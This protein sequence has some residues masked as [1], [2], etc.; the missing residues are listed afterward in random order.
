MSRSIIKKAA[1]IGSSTLVS[2]FFAY[3]REILLIQF[4]GV[5]AISDA[6][7]IAL[8]VPNS[9]RKV[10]AEGALSSVLVPAFIH[11]EQKYGKQE[12][13]KLLTV[14]FLMIEALM[15][16]LITVIC[17]YAP[18]FVHQM[19][20]GA[21]IESLHA[22]IQFLRI[23]APFILL[24]SS[25]SVLAA[26]LQAS[27]RFL[28]PG[29]APV[30]L[31]CL[32]VA[33]LSLGL[34]FSWSVD[35]LCWSWVIA[36]FINL[37]LHVWVCMLY[38]FEF[39]LPGAIAWKGFL[40]VILQLFP[41]ILSVGIGEVNFLI[42]SRFASYLQS[43]TLSLIRTAYQLVNIPLGVIA[44]SLSIVLLPYFSKI[45]NSKKELGV[46]L[47]EAI[48]FVIWMILPITFIMMISSREIFQTMFLSSKFTMEHVFQAQSNMN[49]YLVGL[50]FFAL[51][52]ILL[53]AFY[54]LQSTGIAT[55]VAIATIA[56][57]FF[58]NRMLIGMYGGMG[59]A[60][61]TSI[62]AGVR[63]AL[64][65]AILAY[66][67]K[68]DFHTKDLM[69]M[70]RNYCVQLFVLGSVFYSAVYTISGLIAQHSF[71]CDLNFRLFHMII[72]TN[73]FLYG[74]GFWSWFGPLSLLFFA[75]IYATR[76]AFGV[77]FSYLE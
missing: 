54:A 77:S 21:S 25:S 73:F 27:H 60:L 13:N 59:L 20:P 9:L 72:D 46:Y 22:S 48:K 3:I 33:A 11:A 61:A 47:A 50:L 34:Y 58:M 7:F 37:L 43:G 17:F 41:C 63:V 51:E 53:N 10:F 18:F 19:A 65:V 12:V 49:A 4:L 32:Y 5:G 38:K 66:Y 15:T 14:S 57:N 2:R 30:I 74:F 45:G 67:F 31:N 64:F 68:V 55:G 42:D 56:L 76:K 16:C 35:V 75:G 40:Q 28:L 62:S 6:F 36:A 24:L 39:R 26:A 70:V 71:S 8:R 44:T 52:K 23:L 29:L 1:G 69:K